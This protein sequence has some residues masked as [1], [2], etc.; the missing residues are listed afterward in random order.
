MEYSEGVVSS[1]V[2]AQ[3]SVW[4][5]VP[6]DEAQFSIVDIYPKAFEYAATKADFA[7]VISAGQNNI[8]AKTRNFAFGFCFNLPRRGSYFFRSSPP[9]LFLEKYVKRINLIQNRN[10]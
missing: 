7:T 9:L 5:F 1:H 4:Y 6:E 2:L 3:M 10:T 8:K